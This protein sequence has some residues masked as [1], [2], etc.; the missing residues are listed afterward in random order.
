MRGA[1]GLCIDGSL[2]SHPALRT[3]PRALGS[4]AL[5][6]RPHVASGREVVLDDRVELALADGSWLIAERIEGSMFE[7]TLS[8]GPARSLDDLVHPYLAP[9]AALV[10][11]WLGNPSFHA[12]VVAR[13]DRALGLL[14]ERGQGKT[15]TAAALQ[16]GAD[17]EVLSDDLLVLEGTHVLP[18]PL[19]LDLRP[20][21]SALLG[22]SGSAVRGGTRLRRALEEPALMQVP[23]LEALVFLEFADKTSL[24]EVPVRE[25]LAC[26]APHLYW[27]GLPYASRDLLRLAAVPSFRLG[28]PYGRQG[29]EAAV[30][31]LRALL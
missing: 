2:A 7:A 4:L 22:L 24:T 30:K 9:I 10:N 26:L 23:R 20:E 1:Y 11:R 21:G 3:L 16:E 27:P 25:R 12:A 29:L 13:G 15:T 31:L 5:R 6:D 8:G 14:G 18:G 17:L 19:T 28:R